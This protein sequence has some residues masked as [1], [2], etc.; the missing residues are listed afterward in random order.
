MASRWANSA[1]IATAVSRA[2]SSRTA[3]TI[4]MRMPR[5]EAPGIPPARA[6]VFP[7]AEDSRRTGGIN[8]ETI[9]LVKRHD[10][11][12][13]LPVRRTGCA[14]RRVDAPRL[15]A[16]EAVYFSLPTLPAVILVEPLQVTRKAP[17][18]EVRVT[19]PHRLPF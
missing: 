15:A 9:Q 2:L 12:G 3:F 7:V 16:T 1:A 10:T 11:P 17:E 19:R 5:T 4:M 6:C 18:Q 14:G 13:A 8:V